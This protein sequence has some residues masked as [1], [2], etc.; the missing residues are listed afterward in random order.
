MRALTAV[1]APPKNGTTADNSPPLIADLEPIG[2]HAWR[3]V[4]ANGAKVNAEARLAREWLELRAAV[5]DPDDQDPARLWALL[6][7]NARF[8]GSVR[9]VLGLD[10]DRLSARADVWTG[11]KPDLELRVAAAA[12]ALSSACHALATETGDDSPVSPRPKESHASTRLED[13]CREA[14]WAFTRRGGGLEV[15]LD[16]ARSSRQAR[17]AVTS[18]ESV[19]AVV[20]LADTAADSSPSCTAIACVLLRVAAVVRLVKGVA[21]AQ[22]DGRQTAALVAV[23]ES[24]DAA[25]GVDRALSALATACRL[26]EREVQALG[27]EWLARRYLAR[28]ATSERA[29]PTRS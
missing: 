22:D 1:G 18:G 29:A 6:R 15:P 3:F 20:D 24:P 10:D 13:L 8:D 17:V 25:L 5:P 4:M 27:N 7:Q 2:R 21:L 28:W 19:H 23:S 26:V 9:V 14:G 12:T 11:D 16:R